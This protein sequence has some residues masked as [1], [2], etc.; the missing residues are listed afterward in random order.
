MLL[1]Q[2]LSELR[3]QR[4]GDAAADGRAGSPGDVLAGAAVRLAP[5][6]VFLAGR[7]DLLAE[8]EAR[9][10]RHGPRMP[11]VAALCGLGGT[12]KTSVAVEY[13]YRHL[14]GCGVVWQFAAEEPAALAAGFDELAA[15]LAGPGGRAGGDPV[16][17]VH[18]WLAHRDDWLLVFDNVP[19]PARVMGLLPSAGGGRVVPPAPAVA[20]PPVAGGGVRP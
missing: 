14:T 3:E 12:G 10:G 17:A 20:A 1:F 7:E 13:A 8:L 9:L 15:Q 16:A 4:A 6:P 2:A 18:G 11:G 5:R 19:D